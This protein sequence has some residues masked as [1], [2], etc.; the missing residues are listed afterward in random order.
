MDQNSHLRVETISFLSLI[1]ITVTDC[2]HRD[3][4]ELRARTNIALQQDI[5]FV[6]LLQWYNKINVTGIKE[7]TTTGSKECEGLSFLS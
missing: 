4:V 7:S 6:T 2:F 5:D 1:N 3:E